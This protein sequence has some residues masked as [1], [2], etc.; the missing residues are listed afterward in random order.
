MPEGKAERWMR[1]MNTEYADL[2]EEERES[3]RKVVREHM[4]Q[5]PTACEEIRREILMSAADRAKARGGIIWES[6]LREMA[7]ETD[8]QD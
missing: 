1:Q 8:V 4:P 2:S 7:E 5:F 3:D 6:M